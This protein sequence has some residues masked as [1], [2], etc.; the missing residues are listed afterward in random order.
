[1]TDPIEF[2]EEQSML[3]ETANDFCRNHSSIDKV[4]AML[5]AA[6][7][8]VQTWQEIAELGWLGINVPAEFGGL[9]LGLASVVPIVESMGR[10]LMASPYAG[11]VIAAEAITSSGSA[12]QKTAWLPRIVSGSIATLALCESDGS[13]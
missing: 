10:H 2:T 3:L 7:I 8:D 11:T 5:D 9:D 13:W 1:M 4:R 12:D 6:E